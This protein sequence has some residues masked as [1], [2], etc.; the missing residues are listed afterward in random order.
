MGP[1]K[2]KGKEPATGS[3]GKSTSR[4]VAACGRCDCM[5]KGPRWG[6]R[7]GGWGSEPDTAPAPGN[8][9]TSPCLSFPSLPGCQD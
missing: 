2:N 5:K 3:V 9:L 8:F 6:G 1:G 4:G 7:G